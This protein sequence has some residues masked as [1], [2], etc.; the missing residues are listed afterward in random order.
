[1]SE[2]KKQVLLDSSSAILL[3]KTD[4]LERFLDTYAVILTEAV[5]EELTNNSYPSARLFQQKHSRSHFEVIPLP[6]SASKFETDELISLNWGER[7]TILQFL[8]GIGDFIMIDDGKAAKYCTRQQL[9]FINA[10]LLPIILHACGVLPMEV[11]EKK[12]EEIVGIGRYSEKIVDMA[13]G[14]SS[15][16][17]EMFFP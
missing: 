3:E 14:F 16:E 11:R 8:S 10:L 4:M 5:F 13:L 17:L 12:V 2:K 7:E 9:P 15:K 6:Q 1:M